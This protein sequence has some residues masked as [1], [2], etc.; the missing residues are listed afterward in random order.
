MSKMSLT[1]TQ[2][3]LFGSPARL[4]TFFVKAVIWVCLTIAFFFALVRLLLQYLIDRKWYTNDFLLLA[5]WLLFLG[6][7]IVW[8]VCHKQMFLITSF[9]TSPIDY[10]TLPANI[11]AVQERYLR[12]QLA[13][14]LLS[15]TSL[16]LVKLSFVFFFRHLGNR[17]RAQR[18]LWWVILAFVLACYGG[19]LG[20]LD[21]ACEMASFEDSIG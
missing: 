20:V 9:T 19:V 7:C 5:A 4:T 6:N 10:S 13:G 12:G 18:I 2:I 16:W 14:Y 17:F 21:Y 15:Y 3:F 8:S 1:L 11:A